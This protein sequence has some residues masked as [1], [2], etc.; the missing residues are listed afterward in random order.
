M[1]LNKTITHR[2]KKNHPFKSIKKIGGPFVK[3][4]EARRKCGAELERQIST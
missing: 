2:F 4:R 1:C 3:S